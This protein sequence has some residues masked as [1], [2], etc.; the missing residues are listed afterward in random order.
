MHSE[1]KRE[2]TRYVPGV[3]DVPPLPQSL[4]CHALRL[5]THLQQHLDDSR[6]M[7]ALR[8]PADGGRE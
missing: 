4:G 3:P 2:Q 1:A 6:S 8:G 7:R 5:V